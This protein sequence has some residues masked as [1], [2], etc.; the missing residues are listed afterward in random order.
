MISLDM[1]APFHEPAPEGILASAGDRD[2]TMRSCSSRLRPE[3]R[4]ARSRV[5]SRYA[6][7]RC[8]VAFRKNRW[9]IGGVLSTTACAGS[10]LVAGLAFWNFGDTPNRERANRAEAY[11]NQSGLTGSSQDFFYE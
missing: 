2:M 3:C 7:A 1:E 11:W 6:N 4:D 10:T 9:R 5:D 8:A